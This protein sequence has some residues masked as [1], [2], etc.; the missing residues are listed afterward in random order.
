MRRIIEGESH[1]I[2]HKSSNVT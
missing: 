2:G 1:A